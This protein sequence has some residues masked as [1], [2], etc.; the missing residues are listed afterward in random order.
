MTAEDA[1]SAGEAAVASEIAVDNAPLLRISNLT[2]RFGPVL[3]LGSTAGL[4]TVTGKRP[5]G[6][7]TPSGISARIRCASKRR[8]GC[9]TTRP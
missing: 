4:T 2:V 7:R 3:A 1:V 9:F 6:L 8:W 5:V